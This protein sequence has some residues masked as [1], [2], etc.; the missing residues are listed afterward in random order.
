MAGQG[1]DLFSQ[2]V[3][4]QVVRFREIDRVDDAALEHPFQFLKRLAVVYAKP[5]TETNHRAGRLA[6]SS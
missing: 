2:L 1:L 3:I 5:G 6:G 4:R